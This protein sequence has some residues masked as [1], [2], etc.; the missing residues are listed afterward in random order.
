L[1]HHKSA[2]KRMLQ[3]KKRRQRNK[4]I[5]STMRSTIRSVERTIQ[6][7]DADAALDTLRKAIPI[8]DKAASKGVIHKNK[9]ARHVSRLTRKA[10]ALRA[11]S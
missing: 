6:S 9:A 2:E 11:A 1:A 10:N 5:D 8:I 4:H 3:N 7:K